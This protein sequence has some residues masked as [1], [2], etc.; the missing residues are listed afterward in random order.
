MNFQ[1]A[2]NFLC[3]FA[4]LNSEKAKRNKVNLFTQFKQRNAIIKLHTQVRLYI[5]KKKEKHLL[6]A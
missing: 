1:M 3:K 2:N 4:N 5:Q 6:K